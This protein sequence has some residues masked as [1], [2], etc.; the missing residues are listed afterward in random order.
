MNRRRPSDIRS[1][2]LES[3]HTSRLQ[4]RKMH[5]LW[6]NELRAPLPRK[7][8]RPSATRASVE[9][10]LL[11]SPVSQAMIAQCSAR[12]EEILRSLMLQKTLHKPL[13]A[14]RLDCRVSRADLASGPK[15]HRNETNFDRL[16]SFPTLMEHP[17][18]EFQLELRG[19]QKRTERAA[20]HA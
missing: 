14:E 1:Q 6:G 8:L 15:A 18:G 20:A 2:V 17:H 19:I 10:I 3:Q 16:A 4:A 12:W 7:T 5:S 11:A 9:T 13:S